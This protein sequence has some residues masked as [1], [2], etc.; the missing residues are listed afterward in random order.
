MF[1][2]I[3][4]VCVFILLFV[5][6][7]F[8]FEYLKTPKIQ[9]A[10][11]SSGLGK[12]QQLPKYMWHE[13]LEQS[14]VEPER[15]LCEMQKILSSSVQPS[16]RDWVY[17]YLILNNIANHSDDPWIDTSLSKIPPKIYQLDW[18]PTLLSAENALHT[19]YS[20]DK[21][22]ALIAMEAAVAEIE[23]QEFWFLLPRLLNW[24]G[25]MALS[26]ND[27]LHAQ[28]YLLKAEYLSKLR[29][30]E[31]SLS[32]S[33]YNL[34]KM[35]YK[36]GQWEEALNHIQAARR[37]KEELPS[38]NNDILQIYWYNEAVTYNHLHQ[39]DKAKLAYLKA[40]EYFQNGKK[41]DRY[42]VLDLR[43]QIAISLMEDDY[44]RSNALVQKCIST[45][46]LFDLPYSLGRCYHKQAKLELTNKRYQQ[47][48]S[49]VDASLKSYEKFDSASAILSAMK[50]K[51]RIHESQGN[52]E[53]AYDLAKQIYATEK[54][55]LLLKV[56]DLTH[57]QETFDL[58]RQVDELSLEVILNSNKLDRTNQY[59]DYA[60]W[61]GFLSIVMIFMMYA[62]TYMIKR[63]NA[64]L[65]VRSSVDQLTGL[66]NRHYYYQQLVKG[67]AISLDQ[68][69]HLALLDIDHFKGINDSYGHLVGDE[70]LKQLA[71]RIQP[72]LLPQ[73]LFVRWGG[74]EFLLLIKADSQSIERLER[75]LKTLAIMPFNTSAGG[76]IVTSSIGVS[77]KV[78]PAQLLADETHFLEADERLY[79]AKLQGRNRVVTD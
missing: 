75:V 22:V 79:S 39:Y 32:L 29:S 60:K 47:A 66:H 18:I 4:I 10:T 8:T 14:H 44:E 57:A 21:R 59:L 73:E 54:E 15:T 55:Q 48:L 63:E 28:K 43:T 77:G 7:I 65:V 37:L 12:S 56:R 35:Y 41:S 68:H 11:H 27:I 19:W 5:V 67:E 72:W 16:A 20:G 23:K 58:A 53:S 49:A 69:Y 70:V 6:C 13:L 3:R 2:T 62:R 52:F 45:A 33:N 78:T 64:R 61:L 42:Y 24:A 36:L 30:D 40:S 26:E 31:F 34:Y 71:E 76:L 9:P 51:A 46:T 74:E 1:K 38:I 17:Q 50:L 25:N